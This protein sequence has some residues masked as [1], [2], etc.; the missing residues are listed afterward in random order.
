MSEYLLFRA[1]PYRLLLAVERVVEIAT[2][3]AA[4]A[5]VTGWRRWREGQL[6]ALDLPRFLGAAAAPRPLQLVVDDD[7]SLSIVDVDAVDGLLELAGPDF[8][9]LAELAP[10][11]GALVDAVARA[12]DG[13]GCLLRLRLPL[14]WRD[15]LRTVPEARP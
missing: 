3:G 9:S 1:G 8:A 10:G 5:D 2:A 11:L 6:P 15:H 7:G 14:A 13:D 12:R 4:L